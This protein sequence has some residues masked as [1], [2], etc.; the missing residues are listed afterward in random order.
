MENQPKNQPRDIQHSYGQFD[1]YPQHKTYLSKKNSTWGHRHYTPSIRSK[2]STTW[3]QRHE[4]Q[5]GVGGGGVDRRLT[6][7]GSS[8]VWHMRQMSPG[9]TEWEKMVFP[10]SSVTT[11]VPWR[12]DDLV[13][14]L[15]NKKCSWNTSNYKCNITSTCSKGT[16]TT[17]NF[18]NRRQ[19]CNGGLQIKSQ[20]FITLQDIL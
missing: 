12:R 20:I 4:R 11:T 15:K 2:Y 18:G 9:S 7:M 1:G 8:L 14:Q 19:N 13:F 17:L 6:L 5:R 10:A 16:V 3:H